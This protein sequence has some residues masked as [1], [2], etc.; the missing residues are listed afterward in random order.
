MTILGVVSGLLAGQVTK[1]IFWPDGT[2]VDPYL[3]RY[4]S[5]PGQIYIRA[6]LLLIVPL[7]VSSLSTS[8][9]F[10]E[11]DSNEKSKNIKDCGIDG[12]KLLLTT[13]IFFVCFSTFSA[14]MGISLMAIV[15]PGTINNYV[16]IQTDPQSVNQSN[17]ISTTKRRIEVTNSKSDSILNIIMNI[18]PDNIVT[19]MF[20]TSFAQTQ[21]NWP[22][23][24]SRILEPNYVPDLKQQT[25]YSYKPNMIGICVVSFLLGLLLKKLGPEKTKITRDLL[26]EIDFLVNE[27]F[28]FLLSYMPAGMF[29]WMFS[30]AL[31]MHSITNVAIQLVYFYALAFVAFTILLLVFY[32]LVLFVLTRENPFLLYKHIFPAI[33]VAIGTTSSA[34]TLPMTMQCMEGKG[35]LAK[36]IAQTVLPLGMTIHMN[37]TALYY[38]MVALFVAQIKHIP[39]DPFM[40]V[41]LW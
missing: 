16:I 32:P 4:I 23:N 30:E 34:I 41:V 31:K 37:G 27:S 21:T 22:A 26:K 38:P 13:L 20:S 11:N 24:L 14:A 25:S 15:S 33:L 36:P 29:C 28:G 35:K 6:F 19:L 18:F 39:I 5:L 8:L 1:C 9:L 40:L 3:L 10:T 2:P 17:L 12:R 7:L